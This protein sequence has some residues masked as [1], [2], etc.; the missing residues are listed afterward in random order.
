MS[1]GTRLKE[2]DADIDFKKKQK[3]YKK[4][5]W[6]RAK[7][8]LQ[9]DFSEM[10]IMLFAFFASVVFSIVAYAYLFFEIIYPLTYTELL[11]VFSKPAI[12]FV[13]LFCIAIIP[14]CIFGMIVAIIGYTC[15][16]YY[17]KK[18]L[19]QEVKEFEKD[20]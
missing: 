10:P 15:D 7:K 8:R 14:I 13:A 20:E 9:L 2:L 12:L 17:D 4:L 16:F 19:E 6:E 11:L 5:F 1:L 3:E 18:E